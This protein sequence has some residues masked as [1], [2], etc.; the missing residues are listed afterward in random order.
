MRFVGIDIAAE[1]H[2]VAIVDE[3]GKVLHKATPFTENAAGYERLRGLLGAPEAT[4]VAMEATGHYWQNVFAALAAEGFAVALLN[5]LRTNRFS[6]EELSRAKTDEVD[7]VL[8]ARFA[9][10][11][12]PAATT[13]PD[14]GVLELRE[15]VRLRDRLVQEF[16]DKTRQLHRVVDLG[17]PEFTRCVEDLGSRTATAILLLYPTAEAFRGV[18]TKRLAGLTYDERHKVGTELAER[19]LAAAKTSVGRHHGDAYRVQVLYACEDLDVLRRRI[20]KL[21]KDIEATLAAHKVGTLLTSIDGIGPQT[22]ALLVAEFGNIAQFRNAKALASYAGVCPRTWRS[23]KKNGQASTGGMGKSRL[24][25]ALWMPTI[26]AVRF[27]TWLKP[28][29]ARLR[30]KGKPAKV[31]LIAC[32][33]KLLTAVYFVAKN[34]REFNPNLA[35]VEAKA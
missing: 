2:Y 31:A 34:E 25:R 3:E 29:Y 30:Q 27:N 8:I 6:Q 10:Q 23:G 1:T 32:M 28:F 33:R 7:A 9:A 11:K 21:D 20:K 22:A 19:I 13:L 17:F 24:R 12:K 16:G 5:P 35:L 26:A 4:L 15:L 14:A 18:P